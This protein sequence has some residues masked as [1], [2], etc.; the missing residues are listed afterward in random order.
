MTL[1]NR[2]W[3]VLL[4]IVSAFGSNSPALAARP[5]TLPDAEK[6]TSIEVTPNVSEQ[7]KTTVITDKDRIGQFVAFVNARP[8]GWKRPWFTFPAGEYTVTV[9]QGEKYLAAFWISR[10]ELGGTRYDNSEPK[11][12]RSLSKTE[13]QKL[14]AILGLQLN[15]P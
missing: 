5:V 7:P 13:W 3:I 2:G 10:N 12:L 4:L 15:R 11:Q 9:K 14:Q 8:T 1:L 6:I